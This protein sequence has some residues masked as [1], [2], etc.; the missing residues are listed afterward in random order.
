MTA[1]HGG[2]YILDP[3]TGERT[4]VA[5]TVEPGETPIQPPAEAAP[6]TA[7]AETGDTAA[8]DGDTSRK[9]RPAAG[10]D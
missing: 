3:K 8:G 4:L 7:P 10:K 1:Q 2:S 5:R 9:R 6:D